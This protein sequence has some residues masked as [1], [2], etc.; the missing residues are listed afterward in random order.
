MQPISSA[1]APSPLPGLEPA[2]SAPAEAQRL[3]E[4]AAQEQVPPVPA[5]EQAV[6]EQQVRRAEAGETRGQQLDV[7]A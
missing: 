7:R 1:S 2:G 3:E 4:R 6:A 5:S